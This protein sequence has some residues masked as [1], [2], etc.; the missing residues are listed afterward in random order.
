MRMGLDTASVKFVCAAK[1][2][3]VDFT[4][5]LMI[6]RQNLLTT[7]ASLQRVFSV[8]GIE[9]NAD[10]FLHHNEY[11][12]AF[13]CLM[14]AKKVSSLDYSSYEDASIIH[15]MNS[16][17]PDDLRGRY[18]VVYDGGTLEHVF[19]IPQALKNCM[20]MVRVGGHFMQVHAANNFMGHG[21]WQFSPELIFRAFSATNGY[22]VEAVL[23]HEVLPTAGWV[24]RSDAWYAVTD[25]DEIKQRVEF[26]NS[27]STYILTIAR[28]LADVE[29]FAQ[30]PQQ[31]DYVAAWG[32]HI[33]AKT[34]SASAPD[35]RDL[36]S[37]IGRQRSWRSY[38]PK[39]IK[40]VLR[41][42]HRMLQ[43]VPP[44]PGPFDRPYFKRICE[45]DL[46]RGR[47]K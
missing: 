14:G 16:P 41:S 47:L 27:F 5:T 38:V 30:S 21:F 10:E 44:V 17:I 39:R 19:N 24:C 32:R 36:D 43:P 2:F 6:G 34:E 29:I 12:D 13:F 20:E 22:Q 4:D 33:R 28:K 45:D 37:H 35:S 15:D 42:L 40:R 18:S 25:P 11:G 1:S 8:L 9:M 23:L 46:L 31:S 26:C 3:G 7:A